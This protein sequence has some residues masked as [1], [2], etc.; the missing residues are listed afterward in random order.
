MLANRGAK[1]MFTNL[2]ETNI[3]NS[4]FETRINK[5]LYRELNQKKKNKFKK[6]S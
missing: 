4:N 6:K 3:I 2:E 5:E 1:L